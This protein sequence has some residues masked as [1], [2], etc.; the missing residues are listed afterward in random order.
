MNLQRDLDITQ[1]EQLQT[2]IKENLHKFPY[3]MQAVLERVGSVQS[4]GV[5][6]RIVNDWR[7][8]NQPA[9]QEQPASTAPSMSFPQAPQP[10][11]GAAVSTNSQNAA[12]GHAGSIEDAAHQAGGEAEVGADDEDAAVT[13][14]FNVKDVPP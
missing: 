6:A 8:R 5:T 2:A 14:P 7:R 3:E 9:V 13:E 12:S 11:A 1:K 10:N 4:G